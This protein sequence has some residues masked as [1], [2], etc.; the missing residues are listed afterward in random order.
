MQVINLGDELR[1]QREE[2][3]KVRQGKRKVEK[4]KGALIRWSHCKQGFNY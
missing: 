3:G 1:K 2:V 4:E